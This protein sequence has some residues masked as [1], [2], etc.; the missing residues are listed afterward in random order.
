MGSSR[1]NL[2]RRLA[3][4]NALWFGLVFGAV[5]GAA[6][7]LASIWAF[8]SDAPQPRRALLLLSQYFPAYAPTPAGSLVGFAW[9]FATAFLLALPTAWLYYRG[10]LRQISG[11][12]ESVGSRALTTATA[13]IHLPS[14]ALAFG[15]MSGFG[16]WLATVWLVI[17][18]RPGAPLGPRLALLNQYL[19]GYRV[20]LLGALV[21]FVYLLVLGGVFFA[22]VGWIYNRLIGAAPAAPRSHDQ[23]G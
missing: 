10:V 22:G 20:S 5:C 6:L 3:R 23:A 13:R 8:F 17:Q 9:A 12:G 1:F 19:P 16:L 18:H 2:P 15:L 4:L 11:G 14:F 21:G 7:W